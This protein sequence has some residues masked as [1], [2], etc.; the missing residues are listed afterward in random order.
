MALA[1][2]LSRFTPRVGGGSA[3]FV[4]PLNDAHMF[5]KISRLLI[6]TALGLFTM[7]FTSCSRSDRLQTEASAPMIAVL[8]AAKNSDVTMFKAAYSK[9]IQHEEQHSDWSKNLQEAQ[10]NMK[11]KYGDYQLSDFSYSF[12]GNDLN[13]KVTLSFKGKKQFE[14]P[15]VKEDGAWRL[16]AR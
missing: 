6:L 7:I 8:E 9:R 11:K 16:D 3:F 12:V 15:V 10:A 2:P 13:G 1:V 14:L 5:M 4:R